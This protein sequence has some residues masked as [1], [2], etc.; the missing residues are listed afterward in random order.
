M[1]S[2][3]L[4]DFMIDIMI[5]CMVRT[6]GIAKA[7]GFSTFDYMTTADQ[8]SLRY[9]VWHIPKEKR[10]GAAL[11]LAGRSEFLEKYSETISELNQKGLDVYGFDWCGQGLSNR[12]LSNRHKGFISSYNVYLNDLNQFLDKIVKPARI[13]PLIVIA[14]SMGGHIALRF[15]HDHPDAA[16]MAVLTSPMIDIFSSNLFRRLV[17]LMT[18]IAVKTGFSHAYAIGSGDYT[19]GKFNGNQL[20]SDPVRFMDAIKAIEKNPDL[21]LGGVTYGWLSATL[22]SI[23]ILNRPG[24]SAEITTPILMISGGEDKI[25]SINAQRKICTWLPNCRFVEIPE[26]RHEIFKETDAVRSIVWR[27]FDRFTRI[28]FDPSIEYVAH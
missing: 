24:Y 12:M 19:H 7:S 14:H 4:K 2:Y 18:R 9:G 3:M 23:E 20:T 13:R 10:K 11:L 25:V 26:A 17:K 8:R 21:A 1:L 15:L 28:E 16:D 27:E 5:I 6:N 22:A